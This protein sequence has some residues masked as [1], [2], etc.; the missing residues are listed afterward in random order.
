MLDDERR[1]DYVLLHGVDEF[2]SGWDP[3][4]ISP[5]QAAGMFRLLRSHYANPIGLELFTALERR[6]N[7]K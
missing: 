7:A 1:W 2:E 6:V 4:W 3:S 5:E